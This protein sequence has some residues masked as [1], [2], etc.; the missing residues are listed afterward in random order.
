MIVMATGG[1]L[2][3]SKCHVSVYFYKFRKGRAV[4]KKTR[5]LPKTTFTIPQKDGSEA[6][7]ILLEPTEAKK[8][9]GIKTST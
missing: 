2:K 6:P 7:I 5:E 9:L 4:L 3:P 8:T 1:S